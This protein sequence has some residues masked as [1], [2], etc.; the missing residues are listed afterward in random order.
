LS[1]SI[2]HNFGTIEKIKIDRNSNFL[3]IISKY[4]ESTYKLHIL[5][6]KTLDEVQSFDNI[7]DILQIDDKND[8]VCLD[9]D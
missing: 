8:L 5:N 4:E 7:V 3:L 1:D 9:K 6:R 2:S